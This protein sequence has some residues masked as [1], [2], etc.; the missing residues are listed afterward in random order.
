[1]FAFTILL[2][3]AGC[4]A[5]QPVELYHHFP[6]GL[7]ERRNIL[8]FEIPVEK[9]NRVVDVILIG[10]LTPAF[11][12]EK[13]NV[14]MTMKTP[15]GEERI[16]EYSLKVKS[17]DGAFLGDM[18]DGNYHYTLPLKKRLNLS[19]KGVLVVQIENLVPRL[20]ADGV[21]GIGIKVVDSGK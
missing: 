16:N 6:D 3:F 2:F 10:I 4:S 11:E 20:H 17:P 12:W 18:N 15:S 13:L 9:D 14:N 7:W 8:S 21:S 19:E 5:N 1:M